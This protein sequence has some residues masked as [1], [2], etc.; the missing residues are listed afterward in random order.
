MRFQPE[1]KD[2]ELRER[3]FNFAIACG[4]PAVSIPLGARGWFWTLARGD[5]IC[6]LPINLCRGVREELAGWYG[7]CK[8]LT[9][10]CGVSASDANAGLNIM[11]DILLEVKR[12]YPDVSYGD[13]VRTRTRDLVDVD[14]SRQRSR[15]AR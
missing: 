4:G 14:F 13:L 3:T 15:A 11:Q 2:G 12:K 9:F 1:S 7:D 10:V 8:P 5:R 6:I